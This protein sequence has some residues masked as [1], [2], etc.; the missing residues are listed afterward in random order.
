MHSACAF[1]AC[2]ALPGQLKI[3]QHA[4]QVATLLVT[5]T[6]PLSMSACTVLTRCSMQANQRGHFIATGL[7]GHLAYMLHISESTWHCACVMT[8]SSKCD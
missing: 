3:L 1:I 7:S 5:G 6:A 4:W 2:I 8:H